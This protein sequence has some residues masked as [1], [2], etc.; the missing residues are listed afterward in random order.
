M[1]APQPFLDP[2]NPTLAESGR[3]GDTGRA[4]LLES[5]QWVHGGQR[6]P[7]QLLLPK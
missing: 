7:G 4:L 5:L 2:P 3:G 6:K 1:A